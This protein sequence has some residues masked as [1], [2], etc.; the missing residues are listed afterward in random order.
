MLSAG[1]LRAADRHERLFD[2]LHALWPTFPPGQAEIVLQ[3]IAML[4]AQSEQPQ[5]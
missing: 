3:S 1:D 4:P 5:P 2:T